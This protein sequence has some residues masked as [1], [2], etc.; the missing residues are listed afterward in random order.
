MWYTLTWSLA[1]LAI[2]NRL[3]SHYAHITLDCVEYEHRLQN[4]HTYVYNIYSGNN[5]K[6]VHRKAALFTEQK[7]T[8]KHI[9]QFLFT[10]LFFWMLHSIS[11]IQILFCPFKSHKLLNTINEDNSYSIIILIIIINDDTP[12]LNCPI[13]PSHGV[14]ILPR[15]LIF[16]SECGNTASFID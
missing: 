4:H 11:T 9:L 6:Q 14:I 5:L 12:M 7:E 10:Y 1:S 8:T 13:L 3:P 15:T 2:K 16:I